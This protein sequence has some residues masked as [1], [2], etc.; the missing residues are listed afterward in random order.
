MKVVDL[1]RALHISPQAV[2]RH[3]RN[4]VG[5]GR[6][7]KEGSA[8][9]TLYK[10]NQNPAPVPGRRE[11]MIRICREILGAHPG[12]RFVSLF[13][14]QSRGD[15]HAGSDIDL[16]V[17]LGPTERFTRHEI[18]QYWDR[19]SR[20]ISWASR[21]SLIVRR[22]TVPLYIDTLLLDMPEEHILVYDRATYFDKVRNAVVEW[23]KKNGATRL[24]SFGG[25]HAWR[26]SN[27][28]ER[29]DEIDF[30]LEIMDV[31]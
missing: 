4:L 7:I 8:P 9:H 30:R 28:K 6:V 24:P 27:K 19:Q 11:S 13:G 14:S 5:E 23:R 22:M 16:L 15:A 1:V 20:N 29:L 26:Y 21:V 17:W 18:W 2:H 25:K 10:V 3:L 12:I 31:T